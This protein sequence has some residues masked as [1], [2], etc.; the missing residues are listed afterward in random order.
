MN[1][2]GW[3][4]E[5]FGQTPHHAVQNV[6]GNQ[7]A[8]AEAAASIS[9]LSCFSG[10]AAVSLIQFWPGWPAIPSPVILL[11]W[12]LYSHSLI[13][14]RFEG[15]P[16][17]LPGHQLEGHMWLHSSTSGPIKVKTIHLGQKHHKAHSVCHADQNGVQGQLTFALLWQFPP[18]VALHC[19]LL[20]N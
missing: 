5:R 14:P 12:V 2:E 10:N 1:P 11:D 16:G 17:L 13:S 19:I 8:T 4:G 9:A 6:L 3:G 15:E 7:P 18:M 20:A